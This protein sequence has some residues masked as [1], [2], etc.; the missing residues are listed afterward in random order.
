M[1][2]EEL[3]RQAL[4]A[5]EAGDYHAASDRCEEALKLDAADDGLTTRLIHLQLTAGELWWQPAPGERV[6]GLIER[7]RG[8]AGEPALRAL[9]D[10]LLGTHL[11]A[12]ESLTEA[13][14]VLS[15]AADQA[16]TSGDPLAMLYALSNL[17][18]HMIGRDLDAGMRILR[19][20]QGVVDRPV[21]ADDLPLFR[22]LRARLAGLVGVAEFD[23]GDFGAAEGHLVRSLAELR[24]ANAVDH[25]ATI[26]N[27]LGQL[28]TATGRF[29][30]AERVLNEALDVLSTD[31][32][33]S[34]HHAYNLGL[35]GKLY[36]EWGRVDA[37]A[38][39]VDEAF[40]RALVGGNPA[41]LPLLRN[42]LGEV[43]A[44][45]GHPG[46]DPERAKLLF[47]ETIRECA[48]TGFQRSEIYAEAMLARTELALGDRLA[49]RSAGDRA[50]TRLRE[51]GT[52]PALR[53]EEIHLVHYEVLRAVGDPAADA[54]L[55]EAH[56]ILLRKA[57]TL[58][59]AHRETFLQRV[60]V[61]RSI[62]KYRSSS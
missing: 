30:A 32:G 40:K 41:V 50:A 8:A 2:R 13:V 49:A 6:R 21:R 53:T 4:K 15:S 14:G 20:A 25:F 9:A 33:L 18:H 60:P 27:Y 54:A 22:V 23:A 16:R 61:S 12:T 24:A 17:G 48:R 51:A 43:A 10:C 29:E 39:N 37:A 62:I 56:R 42:Y 31:A 3:F 1:S 55:D 5:Y 38:A 57:A 35:L 26:S 28:L 36:L 59:P 47:A 46:H 11:I 58:P 44:T 19:E 34:T 7:A 52:M 45:P